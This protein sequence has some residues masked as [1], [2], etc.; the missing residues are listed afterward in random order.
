[1]LPNKENYTLYT[2]GYSCHTIPSFINT[3]KKYSI[4]AIADV[5]SEP[6]S[7]FKPEFNLKPLRLELE[8]NGI[9]Y[10]FLGEFCGAR[11]NAPECY[12][13]GKANYSLIAKHPRFLEGIGR[14][15]NGIKKYI[16]AIMCA[17]K[18]PINCHRTILVCRSLNISGLSIKH[19]LCDGNIEDHREIEI[20][21]MKLFELDQPNMLVTESERLDRAYALQ[22]NKIAYE[23][24]DDVSHDMAVGD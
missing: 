8:S 24:S 19:I 11:I 10:V 17:E 14:I 18:D 20:R 22:A 23:P 4:T 13:N 21:L 3:L 2:I 12:V 16:I 5:R 6:Y 7:K 15:K 1:M 9:T